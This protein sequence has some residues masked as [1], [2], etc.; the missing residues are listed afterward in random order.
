MK[1]LIDGRYAY[2][3]DLEDVEVGDEMLLP[4]TISA[5]SWTGIVTSLE[6][7]YDGPCRKAIGLT[8]RHAQVEAEK[9]ALAEVRITG[10]RAGDTITKT[11]AHCGKDR[12][13]QIETVNNIGRPITVRAGSCACGTTALGG[14]FGSAASFR[15][16]MIDSAW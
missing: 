7:A 13:F 15:H 11:C 4:G 1:V 3:T 9:K 5:D 2:E 8:R 12:D 14:S 10:W 6:P 16:F